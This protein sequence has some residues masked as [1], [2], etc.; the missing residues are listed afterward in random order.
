MSPRVTAIDTPTTF[1]IV[2]APAS[3][4]AVIKTAD[5][6]WRRR[7]KHARPRVFIAR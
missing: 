4:Q 7:A 5:A 6:S 3:V 2:F 1:D